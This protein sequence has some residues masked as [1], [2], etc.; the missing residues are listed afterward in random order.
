MIRGP[1]NLPSDHE[2][3]TY[4]K[5]GRAQEAVSNNLN[6]LNKRMNLIKKT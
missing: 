1:Y 2:N 5:I 3:L 6:L 4:E